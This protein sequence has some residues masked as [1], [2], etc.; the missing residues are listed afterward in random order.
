MTNLEADIILKEIGKLRVSNNIKLYPFD[1]WFLFG[2]SNRIYNALILTHQ[3]QKY[4]LLILYKIK[5]NCYIEKRRRRNAPKTS[6]P[7]AFPI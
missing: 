3:Q 1:A 2:I 4:M 6:T 5:N 7:K